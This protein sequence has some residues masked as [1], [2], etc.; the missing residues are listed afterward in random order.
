MK[1]SSRTEA[2]DF[3]YKEVRFLDDRRFEEWLKLF[4]DDGLYWIPLDDSADPEKEPSVLYDDSITRRQRV[5]QLLH[6]PHYS[7][8]PPSRTIHFTSNVEFNAGDNDDTSLLHCNFAVFE[9]RP[10]DPRQF[11]LGDQN[12]LVGRCEYH[13]RYIDGQW[14]I[15]LKKFIMM[16]RDLPLRNLSFIL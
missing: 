3:I 5:Y 14:R 16:N 15:A 13:L 10:G 9:L 11:G 12:T 7:Q 2:E 6:Q 1:I 8:M 4:T